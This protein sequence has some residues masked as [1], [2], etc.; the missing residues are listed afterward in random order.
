MYTGIADTGASHL[1]IAPQ[2]PHGPIN[3]TAPKI[4][5]GSANGQ[6]VPSSAIATL[7]IPQQVH[8]IPCEGHIMP[9]FTNTLVVIGPIYN[10]GCTVTFTSKEVTVYS[11]R[12]LPILTGWRGTHMLKIWR[13]TLSPTEDPTTPATPRNKRT[14]L[15]AYIAYDLPSVAALVRYI[16]A[17]AGFPTKH[18]WL[19][20]I[21]AGNF[22]TC[23][24]PTYSNASKYLPQTTEII[25]GH[26]TQTKQGVRSTKAKPHM[27]EACAH[28]PQQTS[29]TTH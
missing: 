7:P 12:G 25:K 16:H 9:T 29:A 26:M 19:N 18:T 27:V 15:R 24:G 6:V 2:A 23:P 17:A 14:S 10:A 21:K 11:A 5:V 3:T 8:D 28:A 22:D 1:Y 20:A 13:F 4:H